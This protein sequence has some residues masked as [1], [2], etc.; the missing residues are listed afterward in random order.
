MKKVL[1]SIITS[2]II[3]ACASTSVRQAEGP[4]IAPPA[5]PASPS[6]VG[7]WKWFNG[8]IVT[9][10]GDGHALKTTGESGVWRVLD[11]QTGSIEIRWKAGWID[12]L[13]LSSDNL[14]LTGTNQHG[15]R[16]TATRS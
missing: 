5:E 8:G 3:S 7:S 10:T 2:F 14:Q 15:A 13:T 11:P 6:P 12:V 1:L 9:L 16:V 4:A